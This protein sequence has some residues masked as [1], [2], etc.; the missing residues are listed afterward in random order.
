[1]GLLSLLTA[2]ITGALVKPSV[3]AFAPAASKIALTGFAVLGVKFASLGF[4]W[5]PNYLYRA[6]NLLNFLR[7]TLTGQKHQY[8]TYD[9]VT[10]MFRAAINSIEDPNESVNK[11]KH[12]DGVA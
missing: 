1:M 6:A 12:E 8:M 4:V 3:A 11:D 7:D 5:D 10:T 2:P 9:D